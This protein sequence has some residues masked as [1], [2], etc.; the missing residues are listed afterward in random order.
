MFIFVSVK[1]GVN[2]VVCAIFS[3]GCL[4]SVVYL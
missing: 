3:G 1:E 2:V 4:C